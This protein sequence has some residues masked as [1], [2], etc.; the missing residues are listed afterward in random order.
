MRSVDLAKVRVIIADPDPKSLILTRKTLLQAGFKDIIQG[1]DL[2]FITQ[3]FSSK[4]P[5]LLI[6]EITL[7]DGELSGFVRKI[8]HKKVGDNPFLVIAG[9]SQTPT[10]E[11]VT[12]I[13]EA[14]A[15]DLLAKPIA[16]EKLHARLIR[17]I[18]ERKPFTIN[19]NY[20]GPIRKP[21]NSF[22]AM[23]DRKQVPNSLR[24]K[25]VDGLT[26]DEADDIIQSA[27]HE[28]N[29][30]MVKSHAKEIELHIKWLKTI[31]NSSALDEKTK[32]CVKKLVSIVE[33]TNRRLDGSNYEHIGELCM[34]LWGILCQIDESG[35]FEKWNL[36]IIEQINEAIKMGIS[37][38][39]NL[40]TIRLITN[41]V[42]EKI[43]SLKE[44]YSSL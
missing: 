16:V 22:E 43:N 4:M 41:V 27:M 37:T 19:G 2:A 8:R 3:A 24:M 17:L 6:S 7:P 33:D 26:S 25:A 18:E 10:P 29:A 11:L 30:S 39:P 42:H 9:L 38:S 35:Q 28:V 14:G 31:E 36:P 13:T 34:A 1:S 23:A 12:R 40:A 5:E 20:I 15:D 32:K 21:R 44:Q